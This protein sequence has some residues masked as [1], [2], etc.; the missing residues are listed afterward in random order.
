MS[1][2]EHSS[3]LWPCTWI[4]RREL[5][6]LLCISMCHCTPR[7]VMYTLIQEN[8]HFSKRDQLPSGEWLPESQMVKLTR[9]GKF[10]HHMGVETDIGMCLYPEEAVYLI[11][12]VRDSL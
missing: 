2:I 4:C 7:L 1:F 12:T 8:M 10:W 9:P 6:G 3:K 5:S 11:D